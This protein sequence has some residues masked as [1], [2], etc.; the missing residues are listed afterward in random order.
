MPVGREGAGPLAEKREG[1]LP[2]HVGSQIALPLAGVPPGLL[3]A[4]TSELTLDNPEYLRAVKYGRSTWDMQPKIELFQVKGGW[5]IL[6]RG[7]GPRLKKLLGAHRIIPRWVDRRLRL[8]PVEFTS[9]I[10]LRDYQVPAVEALVKGIQGGVVAG[11]GAGKTVILLEALARI[12]Q[13]ALWIC[14]THELLEQTRERAREALGLGPRDLGTVASGE[15]RLGKKLT[16]ALIQTLHRL[17]LDGL[18]RHFGMVFVDEAHHLAARTFFATVGRFPAKY[19]LWASATPRRDD[20]LT[21][22]VFACGGPILYTVG[23]AEP[24]RV[25]PRLVVVTTRFASLEDHYP[26]LISSL[27]EDPERNRLIAETI[28]REGPGNYSL[29]LSERVEHLERL[30]RLLAELA[31][32]LRAEIL[33]GKLGKRARKAVMQ[34]VRAKEVDVLLATQLAREGLDIVHLNRLFLATPK[35]SGSALQQEVGRIMRPGAGKRDAV[36]FDFWDLGSPV[37]KAQFWPRR[38][39]YRKL[40]IYFSRDCVRSGGV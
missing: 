16:L 39:V 3:R 6:P 29:V 12:K 24:P 25:V 30:Q 32:G 13:P 9:R 35:R 33:T 15:A 4:V 17:D 37:L 2:V 11:C 5:L 19:R 27:V 26:R 28:A 20:G 38:E 7:Y 1:A 22:M 14:H 36:V 34:R 8:P 40:G 21:K 18:A 31:P 23:P 10:L